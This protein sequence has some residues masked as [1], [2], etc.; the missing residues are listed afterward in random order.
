V[1]VTAAF[2]F[3]FGLLVAIVVKELVD[4]FK[5]GRAKDDELVQ[6]LRRWGL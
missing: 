2:I 4:G 3:A 1:V 6:R 5:A